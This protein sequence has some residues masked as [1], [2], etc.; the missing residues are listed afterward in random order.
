MTNVTR[1]A[2][3]TVCTV[4]LAV[5]GETLLVEVTDD[6]VGIRPEAQAGVGLASLRERAA[7][8][9]GSSEITCPPSGGTTVRTRI[10]LR[11]NP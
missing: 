6:G 8:L 1:H 3:A 10:P 9:G 2:A 5:E 11:R 4:R 7:E